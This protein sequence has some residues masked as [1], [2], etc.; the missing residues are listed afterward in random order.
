MNDLK[1]CITSS[2]P[3]QDLKYW[4]LKAI[5]GGAPQEG[6][7]WIAFDEV[8]DVGKRGGGEKSPFL[9]FPFSFP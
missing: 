9:P 4:G 7:A 5:D 2:F 3:V 8:R 1:T 6:T